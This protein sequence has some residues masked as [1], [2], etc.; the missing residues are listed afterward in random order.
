[1]QLRPYQQEAKQKVNN[2]FI[3]GVNKQVI[4]LATGTGK[5]IIF[6]N[7]INTTSARRKPSY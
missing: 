2:S 7:I 5:T 3:D 6:S 4:V 1:M